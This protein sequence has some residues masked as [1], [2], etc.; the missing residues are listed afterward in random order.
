MHGRRQDLRFSLPADRMR[1][2]RP[3]PRLPLPSS[4]SYLA[5]PL[6]LKVTAYRFAA[7][8]EKRGIGLQLVDQEVIHCGITP[9]DVSG[10]Y[11]MEAQNTKETGSKAPV[12]EF[13][14]TWS[15]AESA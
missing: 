9:Y 5:L 12:P 14:R 8:V 11:K 3:R 2:R 13:T 7:D 4:S 6:S 1:H 15:K 10:Q